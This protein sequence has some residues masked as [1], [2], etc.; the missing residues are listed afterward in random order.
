MLLIRQD[1]SDCTNSDVTAKDPSLIGGMV[2]VIRNPDGNTAVKV[3]IT[4]KANTTYHF[5]LK[6]SGHLGDITTEDEG[7]GVA[8]FNFLTSS[9]G[10][11]YAFDMYPEG[12]PAESR[13]QSVKVEFR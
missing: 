2:R 5:Y 11:T 9:M 10:P 7:Q 13:Y 3:A 12:A 4:A 8:T 1:F 6:C